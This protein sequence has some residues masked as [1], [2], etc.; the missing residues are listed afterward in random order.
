MGEESV[1]KGMKISDLKRISFHLGVCSAL[2]LVTV[3]LSLVTV[4]LMGHII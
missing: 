2:C 3:A 4:L 1:E